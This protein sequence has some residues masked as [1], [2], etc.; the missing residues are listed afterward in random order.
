[1][2]SLAFN[3]TSNS[4]E[5]S[6]IGVLEFSKCKVA[7]IRIIPDPTAT[8]EYIYL[9]ICGLDRNRLVKPNGSS[10]PYFFS[11]PYANTNIGAS[12][13]TTLDSYDYDGK[14][15]HLNNLRIAVYDDTHN[16]LDW[17]ST[18]I[19]LELFYN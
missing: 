12:Q 9:S 17:G 13:N 18:K 5:F 6:H 11:I 14:V 8:T 2:P 1:M 4:T 16:L 19:F 3:L 10:C 15:Q 7:K